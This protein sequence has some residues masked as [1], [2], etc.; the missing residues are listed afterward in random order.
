MMILRGLLGGLLLAPVSLT[1]AAMP[2]D[3]GDTE[4]A[5]MQT[6]EGVESGIESPVSNPEIADAPPL[7]ID[8][9]LLGDWGGWRSDRATEGITFDIQWT[10]HV[11]G[12]VSGGL[13]TGFRYGGT[14]DYLIEFDL[15]AMGVQPGAFVKVLAESRYGES[16]LGDVGAILP[17]NV[18]MSFP[19]TDGLDDNV[20]ITVTELSFTQFFSPSFGVVVGKFQ[21]LDGDPNEFASGR[22]RSQFMNASLVFNPVTALA[23]PYSTLGAGIVV[24]PTPNVTIVSMVYNTT[25]S[26]TTTGFGDIGDGWTWTTEAPFQYRLGDLPGGQNVAFIYADDNKFLNFNR[27]T[28]LPLPILL[29]VENDTWAAYW[30]GWQYLYTPDEVPDRIDVNDGRADLRGIGLFARIGVA[31]DDTNPIEL[32]LSA[33]VGGRGMLPGRDD[34]TFGLGFAYADIDQS[35]FTAL[36]GFDDTAYGVEAFYN[37]SL[38]PGVALTV[39][40][41]LVSAVIDRVDTA[42]ILGARLN[43]RF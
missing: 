32:S 39:D 15:D 42:T 17:A 40:A 5:H 38:A 6:P 19:L 34:D 16:V 29:A 21:T 12:V 35:P 13:D 36:L 23:V 8:N 7:D 20:A 14:L 37:L 10:Q 18:D 31:D 1:A 33:G 30:S 22:G 24:L 2:Q 43:I 26:S 27:S 4:A 41:Q 3:A 11:Q 25:D 28:I 9:F